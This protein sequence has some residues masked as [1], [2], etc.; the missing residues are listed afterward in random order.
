LAVA[1]GA[2]RGVAG[3]AVVPAG[4]C[5]AVSAVDGFCPATA[6]DAERTTIPNDAIE[7]LN[8]ISP[9]I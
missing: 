2:V 7:L 6:N 3:V 8:M 4:G 1:P 9:P 5:L